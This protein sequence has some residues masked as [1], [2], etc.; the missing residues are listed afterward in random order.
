MSEPTPP[1][2]FSRESRIRIDADG[3]VWHEGERVA[4]PGLERAL[5]SWVDYDDAAGRYVLRNALDWCW[6]AVDHTPLVVRA[7]HVGGEGVAVTL[8]DGSREPLRL[9]TLR[10]APDG[11]TYAYVRGGTL[12]ARFDRAAAF[13]LLQHAEPEGEGYVLAL[14]GGRSPVGTLAPGAH[15]PPRPGDALSTSS[16]DG[17]T[18][19]TQSS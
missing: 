18:A 19:A 2:R 9:D 1:F 17:G 5:A 4:H 3:R 8:S 10:V 14:A 13:A 16:T 7:V 15:L 6:V 12:L 11:A